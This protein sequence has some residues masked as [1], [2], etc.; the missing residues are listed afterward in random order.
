MRRLFRLTVLTGIGLALLCVAAIAAGREAR[1]AAQGAIPDM[2]DGL[3]CLMGLV[4]GRTPWVDARNSLAALNANSPESR[5]I[6]IPVGE[7]GEVTLYPSVDRV[8]VGRI[9]IRFG[10]ELHLPAGWIVERFGLPCGISIY[11]DPQMITL[12]YPFLLANVRFAQSHFD[13]QASVISVQFSDPAFQPSSQLDPCR[14]N[15]TDWKVSNR[16]WQ[17]FAS[18]GRYI[19]RR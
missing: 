3:P 1:A 15:V 7:R 11:Y 18:V 14:D 16:G 2:C 4:P 12:R 13:I 8:S 6:V 10:P 17:G 9:N 19:A 5:Q